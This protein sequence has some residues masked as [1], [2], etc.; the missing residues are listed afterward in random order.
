[1]GLILGFVLIPA[2]PVLFGQEAP[3]AAPALLEVTAELD[4]MVPMRDGVNL[5]ADVY[6]P[7][8]DGTPIPGGFPTLLLRTPYSKGD[9]K[10][11]EAN[12]FAERGYVVVLQ[13]VRGTLPERRHVADDARRPSG[14]LRHRRVD[15]PA[16]L[17]ATARSEPSVPAILAAPSMRLPR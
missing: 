10:N 14:R 11:A 2:P 6:R 12:Y 17:V 3:Q 4:V 7:S 16:A 5:A 9:G 8:R 1:M 15:R 13:D